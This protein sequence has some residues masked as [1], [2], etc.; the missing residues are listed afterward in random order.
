MAQNQKIVEIATDVVAMPSLATM[1]ITVH[2]LV[3][4]LL[5]TMVALGTVL[6]IFFRLYIMI[7]RQR[8]YIKNKAEGIQAKDNRAEV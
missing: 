1:A 6:T 8:N 3:D 2:Q 4:G 5:G 7:D